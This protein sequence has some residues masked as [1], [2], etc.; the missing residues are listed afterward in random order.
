MFNEKKRLIQNLTGVNSSKLNYY[1][2]LKK[3]NKEIVMQ[4]NRLEIIHQLTRDMNIDMS[5]EDIIKRVYVKLPLVV[6]CDFIGLGLLRRG[7]LYISA[8]MPSIMHEA[9]PVPRESFLWECVES[10]KACVYSPVDGSDVFIKANP[11]LVEKSRTLAVYPLF[12]RT[13]VR[14]ILLVGSKHLSAYAPAELNFLHQLADQ[15]AIAIQNA[16]LYKQ[17]N[18]AKNE[19]EATFKAVIDPIILLDME[20]NILRCNDRLPSYMGQNVELGKGAKCYNVLWGRDKKCD[21]CPMEETVSTGKPAYKRVQMDMGVI[22]DIYYYPVYNDRKRITGTILHMKDVTE[23][24][25]MEAQLIQSAK[26]AAIGEMAAGVAHELNNPMTVIIGTAQMMLRETRDGSSESEL[27]RD[28]INCGLRCKKIIQNLLTFSRQ[29]QQPLAPTDIN[30]VVER[31]LSL[32]Q[33][34]IN[35][36][37]IEIVKNLSS[38]LPKIIANSQQLQQVLINFLLNARDALEGAEEGKIEINTSLREG[39]DGAE[40]IAVSVKDN[41]VGIAPENLSKIFNPFYTSKESTKGTG[42]GLSVSLGIAEAHG[43]F[44]EVDSK[45]GKGSTFS[46][47][48]PVGTKGD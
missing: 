24:T 8:V 10:E 7:G 28:I 45:P 4:N 43:G 29:D 19:W 39:N 21:E 6:P 11:A 14:G 9:K 42:L 25:K 13:V 1:I 20:F 36:N 46:L 33:Y 41:G 23:K 32:I 12:C 26:L 37:K 47:V 34:Q 2:E 38:G 16:N 31:V 18:R 35:K 48:L 40:Q 3:R 22:Y 27:L 30:D 44:I 17:V 15:L 5:I